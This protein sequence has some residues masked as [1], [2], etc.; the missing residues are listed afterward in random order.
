MLGLDLQLLLA[1]LLELFVVGGERVQKGALTGVQLEGWVGVEVLGGGFLGKGGGR[2]LFGAIDYVVGWTFIAI[3]NDKLLVVLRLHSVSHFLHLRRLETLLY[4][5][6]NFIHILNL[7]LKRP[8]PKYHY[9]LT[10]Q[11][12]SSPPSS[13]P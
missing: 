10:V 8:R 5:P 3:D 9:P 12:S 11:S 13:Y 2:V 4:R 1:V 6:I 7:L